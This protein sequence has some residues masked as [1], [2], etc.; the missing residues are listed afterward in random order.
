MD[1]VVYREMLPAD[2]AA[3]LASRNAVF[4]DDPPTPLTEADWAR[5]GIVATIAVLEGGAPALA[6]RFH[7]WDAHGTRGRTC[8][9][10]GK[11]RASAN[12]GQATGQ[13]CMSR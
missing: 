8:A 2:V 3:A 1:G 13:S 9:S 10:V 11:P 6:P 5:D 12:A 7:R 4:V